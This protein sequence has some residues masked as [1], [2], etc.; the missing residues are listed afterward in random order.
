M[1][2][3]RDWPSAVRAAQAG[4]AKAVVHERGTWSGGELI[5]RASGAADWMTRQGAPAGRAV[6][7]LV[8]SNGDALALLLAGAATGRPLAPLGPKLTPRELVACVERLDPAVILS[9]P[10]FERLASE[11]AS[12]VGCSVA[13]VDDIPTSTLPLP[14][15]EAGDIALLLHTSGTTGTPKSVRY[16]HRHLLE[17][18]RV[19]AGLIGLKPGCVFATGA[20]FH[21][22]AGV[23][24]LLVALAC[25]ATAVAIPEF[26]VAAWRD[27]RGRDVTHAL[28]VPTMI[29]IL[30][31]EQALALPSLTTLAYGGS[32]IHRQTLQDAMTALPQVDF[33]N[34]FGQTEGSPLTYLSPADHRLIAAGREDLLLSVGRAVPGVELSIDTVPPTA[35]ETAVGEIFARGRHLAT[36]DGQAW[37]HTGDLGRRDKDGY[38][39]LVGRRGDRIIR[40]G[41]HI[42]PLEVE[43]VLATHPDVLEIAVAG[44]PDPVYGEAVKAFVVAASAE[45]PPDTAALRSYARASLAGFKV[46]TAWSFI[47]ALPRNASGKVLRRQLLG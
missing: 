44:V 22:I 30:L 7:A 34:L 17:R 13:V 42:Y 19:N 20:P 33:L 40:G 32:P 35:I 21:H 5:E 25:G 8:Q 14:S 28:L 36:G 15:A 23:G 1:S 46:P 27:L 31:R 41:E 16:T 26:S 24:N 4:A 39:Y 29:E 12:E 18:T 11:V 2:A 3:P 37:L 45:H 38:L 47:P 6:P 10:R 9:D 43:T